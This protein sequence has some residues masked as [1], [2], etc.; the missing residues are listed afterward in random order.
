[1]FVSFPYTV[2][3]EE[4]GDSVRVYLEAGVNYAP[5]H[6]PFKDD[7]IKLRAVPENTMPH[8]PAPGGQLF[9]LPPPPIEINQRNLCIFI[10]KK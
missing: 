7:V 3:R 6:L 5:S 4:A 8:P 1:M 9:F 2:W 10:V